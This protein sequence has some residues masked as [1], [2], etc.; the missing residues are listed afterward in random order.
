MS[1]EFLRRLSNCPVMGAKKSGLGA[2]VDHANDDRASAEASPFTGLG[3]QR[4]PA[5]NAIAP[6]LLSLPPSPATMFNI[7]RRYFLASVGQLLR[8]D[9]TRTAI[10]FEIDST[11]DLMCRMATMTGVILDA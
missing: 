2:L 7:E 5:M 8:A 1:N 6:R 3:A 9:V 11:I 4:E 10:T